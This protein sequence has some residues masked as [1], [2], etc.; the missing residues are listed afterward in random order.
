MAQR[1]STRS[2]HAFPARV[3]RLLRA[4]SLAGLAASLPCA[5][6][7]LAQSATH[8][9]PYELAAAAGAS[10]ITAA[11]DPTL[12]DTLHLLAAS[13]EPGPNEEY[14][15]DDGDQIHLDVSS[16]AELTG[17]YTLGPDGRITIPSVG[18]V[19]LSGLSREQAARTVEKAMLPFYSDPAVTVGVVHYLSNHILLLGA[20]QRPGLLNFDQPPT[21]LQVLSRGGIGS[22]NA[23]M[24]DSGNVAAQYGTS[25]AGG[26]VVPDRAFIYRGSQELAVVDLK[27]LLSG[28]AFADLR[29]RRNDI[30]LIPVENQL[31]SVLGAVKTPGAIRYN[32]ES[33]LQVMI[34]QAGGLAEQAGSNPLIQVVNPTTG[35]NTQVRFQQLLDPHRGNGISLHP[36][37]VIFV[38]SSG[39]A[40]FAYVVDK[41]N[42]ILTVIAFS[43]LATR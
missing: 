21:L 30:V 40:K 2:S 24:N 4:L 8:G 16:R 39:F 33:T 9:Q 36:G 15:L 7:A 5:H 17:D 23:Q 19:L 26:Y 35:T 22:D 25:T 20:V 42:P 28:G 29:L 18:S 6:F 41:M 32:P 14:T 37:D 10:P 11:P 31:I 43:T 27:R 38:P 1:I 13:F 3:V 12:T 34:S